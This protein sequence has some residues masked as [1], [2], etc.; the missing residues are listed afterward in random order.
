MPRPSPRPYCT[1]PLLTRARREQK[2]TGRADQSRGPAPRRRRAARS[3]RHTRARARGRAALTRA[4]SQVGGFDLI[5]NGGPVRKER[6][7]AGAGAGAGGT[8]L[9]AYNNRVRNRQRLA[10]QQRA[11]EAHEARAGR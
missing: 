4:R 10:Q 9:G 3:R 8:L 6:A 1:L 2:L 11:R 5:F 7:G